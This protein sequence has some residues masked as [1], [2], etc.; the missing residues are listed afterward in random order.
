MEAPDFIADKVWDALKQFKRNNERLP[1][2]EEFAAIQNKVR[3]EME[4]I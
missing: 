3:N 1:S 4:E 2:K